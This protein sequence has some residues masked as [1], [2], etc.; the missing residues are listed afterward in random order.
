MANPASAGRGFPLGAKVA[1][2]Q[3]PAAFVLGHAQGGIEIGEVCQ[4]EVHVE[5]N[6]CMFRGGHK[7]GVAVLQ[8]G[9][10]GR[11]GRMHAYGHAPDFDHEA[12]TFDIGG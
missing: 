12:E 8:H 5:G 9:K 1:A 7:P 10:K 3:R 11:V 2:L 6:L 4:S